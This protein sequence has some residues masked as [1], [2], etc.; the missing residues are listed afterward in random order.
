[1]GNRIMKLCRKLPEPASLANYRHAQPEGTWDNMR[2]DP[3]DGGQQAYRDIKRTVVRG[4]RC[5]CAFCETRIADGTHDD[6]IDR[7]RDTQRVEHFHPKDDTHA[8]AKLGAA[9]AEPMGMLSRW[10]KTTSCRRTD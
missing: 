9:L 1:M 6:E 8:S 3:H 4:Q 5:L 2:D 10:F 7:K